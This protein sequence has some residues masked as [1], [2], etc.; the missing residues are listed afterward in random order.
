[1]IERDAV[2][3]VVTSR[4][5]YRPQREQLA[6][7]HRHVPLEEA[8]ECVKT[9]VGSIHAL[10]QESRQSGRHPVLLEISPLGQIE[11]R[12]QLEPNVFGPYVRSEQTLRVE[13][14]EQRVVREDRISD[15]V[16][17]V[18]HT[19]VGGEVREDGDPTPERRREPVPT[20]ERP[21]GFPRIRSDPVPRKL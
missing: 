10:I 6:P 11:S 7:V 13:R 21:I 2:S 5:R 19:H 3:L 18:R 4:V 9:G 17:L 20:V 12:V 8:R 15:D 16:V 1:V 14:I